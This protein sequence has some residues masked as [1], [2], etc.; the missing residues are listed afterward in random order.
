MAAPNFWND[1]LAAQRVAQRESKLRTQLEPW[2]ALYA[3]L[4]DAC[5]LAASGDVSLQAELAEQV[6]QLQKDYDK[7]KHDLQFNG[8]FDDHDAIIRLSAGVGGTDA[9]DWTHML[10]R[11]YLRAAEKSGMKAEV[12]EESAGE[13]AG[14]KSATLSFSGPYAYGK[15]RSEHGVHRL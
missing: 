10:E 9:Q 11:M 13:E 12:I 15:L 7:L 8:R 1:N 3:E 4:K 5:E 6:A 14:L 2:K